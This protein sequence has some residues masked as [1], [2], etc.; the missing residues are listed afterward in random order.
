MRALTASSLIML[1]QLVGVAHAEIVVIGNIN[2][3]FN[4]L[5]K[6]KVQEI[7]MGRSREL[8]DGSFALPI[9]YTELRTEFYTRLTGRPIDQ[10]NAY[11]ARLIFSGQAIPPQKIQNEQVLIKAVMDNK[12]VLTYVEKKSVGT[13]PVKIL[14]ALE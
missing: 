11:W 3:S 7:Y 8:P 9:D 14:F 2:A 5:S 12:N 1:L 10:V 4:S 13:K 6:E